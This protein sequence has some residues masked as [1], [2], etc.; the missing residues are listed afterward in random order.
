[1]KQVIVIRRDLTMRRGKEIAQG[2]HASQLSLAAAMGAK[3]P[4]GDCEME[5][6]VAKTDVPL[7]LGHWGMRKIT[8]QVWSEEALLVLFTA[9][10]AAGLP[11][12]LIRDEGITEFKIGKV[13]TALGIGPAPEEEMDVVTAEL[14]LY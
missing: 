13:V 1:M 2:A 4:V 5:P 10:K 8:C 12:A 7:W 9:A 11:C 6:A 14:K 3:F